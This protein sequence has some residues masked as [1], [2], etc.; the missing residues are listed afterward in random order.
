MAKTFDVRS[1]MW[2]NGINTHQVIV[3]HTT[4][5]S[6]A[7]PA[8]DWMRSQQSG[9]YQDLVDT[10][11]DVYLMV[12]DDKQAWAA[13]STGNRIG[14][15]VCAAGFAR[16]SR[17]QWLDQMP[18]LDST[19]LIYAKWSAR[20]GIPLTRL[21]SPSVKKGVRGVCGHVDI[22]FA[23]R[24]TDHTDPGG[25]YPYDVVIDKA[26]RVLDG[27]VDA[28]DANAFTKVFMTPIGS[29]TKDIREQLCGAASRDAGQFAGW[30]QLGNR[31]IADGFGAVMD[32]L[33]VK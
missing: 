30:P 24:E 2:N 1:G 32:R 3:Q 27:D 26:L 8:Y 9:S 11:G 28:V 5:S 23:F 19:A 12:P 17:A 21:G 25:Q 16:M 33:G 10:N 29:D 13:M 4:E 18:Q 14:L 6:R 15:H 20:Y 7:K 22:S 31:T